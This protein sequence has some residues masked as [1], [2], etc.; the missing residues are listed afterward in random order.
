MNWRLHRIVGWLMFGIFL[1]TGFYQKFNWGHIDRGDLLMRS[2]FRAR[3]IY[4]LLSFL[5]H[6][7]I[8]IYGQPQAPGWRQTGQT[9]GSFFLFAGSTVLVAAY[10]HDPIH[11]IVEM[12]WGEWGIHLTFLGS[13]LH[14][15]SAKGPTTL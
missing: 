6:E 2:L 1:F 9:I 11:K 14:V 15:I 8:G 5:I 4:L 10:F 3:H 12:S 13:F 7:L